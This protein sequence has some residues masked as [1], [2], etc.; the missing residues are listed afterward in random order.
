MPVNCEIGRKRRRTQKWQA[1]IDDCN[2]LPAWRKGQSSCE[3]SDGDA[4]ELEKHLIESSYVCDT[5]DAV[6]SGFASP[7]H[8][9]LEKSTKSHLDM[10]L[11]DNILSMEEMFWG[12]DCAADKS[13]RQVDNFLV[14]QGQNESFEEDDTLM[15]MPMGSSLSTDCHRII[16]NADVNQET[17]K[18]HQRS[19]SRRASLVHH[20]RMDTDDFTMQKNW[21]DYDEDIG[22]GE[23]GRVNHLL[24]DTYSPQSELRPI[25]PFS[26]CTSYSKIRSNLNLPLRDNESSLIAAECSGEEKYLHYSLEDVNNYSSVLHSSTTDWTLLASGNL[27]ASKTRDMDNVIVEKNLESQFEYGKGTICTYFPDGEEDCNFT[28]N[29]KEDCDQGNCSMSRYADLSLNHG[30]NSGSW[31]ESGKF[32]KHKFRGSF[33]PNCSEI[34]ADE[35]DYG[36]LRLSSEDR[37]L[38]YSDPPNHRQPAQS[39]RVKCR[40]IQDRNQDNAHPHETMSRRSRSAPPFHKYRKK[41][42]VLNDLLKRATANNNDS[43]LPGALLMQF[44]TESCM[45]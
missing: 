16:N 1:S 18:P 37:V 4:S 26:K 12:N 22:I 8:C 7:L 41:F 31:R 10:Q 9:G 21:M 33:F 40:G 30:L 42:V 20:G 34:F 23:E 32:S 5:N 27:F 44:C 17:L 11:Y 35:E 38:D 36:H 29:M 15:Y 45:K 14:S 39:N 43:L 24:K 13:N 28:L 2:T 25:W 6:S 3:K 19:S